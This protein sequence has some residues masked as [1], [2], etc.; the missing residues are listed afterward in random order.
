[1][2]IVGSYLRGSLELGPKKSAAGRRDSQPSGVKKWT[3]F[4]ALFSPKQ[5]KETGDWILSVVF[6]LYRLIHYLYAVVLIYWCYV[7]IA[8]VYDII[9][10]IS[11][12]DIRP[13]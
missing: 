11:V 10:A 4:T 9:F 12:G 3:F 5:S 13:T 7:F 6:V 1:M 2:L 8:L